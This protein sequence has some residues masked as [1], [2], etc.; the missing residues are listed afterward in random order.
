MNIYQ[1]LIEVRRVVPYLKKVN[2]GYE[3]KFVSS[4]QTLSSLKAKMNELELLL[5]PSVT[6]KNV[7]EVTTSKGGKQHFTELEIDFTWVNAE[8]PEE[9][10]I[11]HWYG[12]GLDTGEKGVGKAL[13]YAEKYYLLKFFNIPTDKDDP[14]IFQEK[15]EN[16]SKQEVKNSSKK[17]VKKDADLELK[18]ELVDKHGGDRVKAKAEYDLIKAKEAEIDADMDN[19]IKQTLDTVEV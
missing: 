9:Q 7:F 18:K 14:D 13:T 8:K 16:N 1:K 5:I 3:Y 12:Q 10:I 15:I 11:S 19:Y 6:S 2:E 17:E 4:S